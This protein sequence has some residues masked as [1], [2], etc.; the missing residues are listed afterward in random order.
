MN[1]CA[2]SMEGSGHVLYKH[3]YIFVNYSSFEKVCLSGFF[4]KKNIRIIDISPHH[5]TN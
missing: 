2:L 4:S 1:V 5:V 3:L